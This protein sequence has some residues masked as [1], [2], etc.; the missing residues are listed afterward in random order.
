MSIY[1]CDKA[2]G[3][4]SLQCICQDV[5]DAILQYALAESRQ[6]EDVQEHPGCVC[7][8]VYIILVIAY[9]LWSLGLHLEKT[10]QMGAKQ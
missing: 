4:V 6:S 3:L 5:D 7:I 8:F 2:A 9:E 1:T 10:F